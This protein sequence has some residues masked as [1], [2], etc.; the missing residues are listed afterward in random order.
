MTLF[1]PKNKYA[2]GKSFEIRIKFLVYLIFALG[3]IIIGKLFDFQVLKFDFYAALASDQH[4]IYQKLFPDRGSIYLEDK[5]LSALTNQE[6]FYP[7][8]LNKDYNLVYA[9]PKYLTKSPQEAA[10]ILA[11]LLELKE[12]D[13]AAKL[14]KPDD[15][16][17][18]LK[19]KV[20]DSLAETIKNLNLAGIKLSKETY[21]YY[22]EKNIGANVTGFVGFDQNNEKKGQ[23]GIEGYFDK[24]LAGAQ[25]E[26]QSEKDI[27]GSLISVAEQKFVRAVDG[28]DIVLTLDKTVQFEVCSQ[29]D[30]HAK[31]IGADSGSAIVMNPKTGAIIAMCSYPD[32]DPNDY[33]KVE[34]ASAYNNRAVYEAY[35][36]GSIFKAITMAAGLDLGVI[37]PDTTYIDEGFEKIDDFTIRN[38]DHLAHGKNTMSEVL[39]HSLNT[40]TIFVVRQMDRKDFKSYVE[41]FG[42]GEK[43]GIQLKSE[44][45]GNIDSLNKKGEIFTATASFGQG[46]TATSL[47]MV[48]AYSAIANGGKMVSPYIVQEIKK[49]DGTIIKTEQPAPKQVISSKTATLLTGMLVNVVEKG[50]GTMAKVPGYYIA[51]KTGTAQIAEGGAY[52]NRTN[53]SF[54]GFAPIKDPAFVMIIKFENPKKG[55]YAATTTAPLFSR[56]S[57]F[58]LDYYHVVPDKL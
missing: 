38:Y 42:F 12:E 40:G 17:E 35:E 32:F 34:D 3:L 43:T 36:P 7:L 49:F 8:A 39:Q 50:E 21:R 23:Y 30:E 33:G 48:Q 9:Q 55:T 19:H 56:L 44:A 31:V 57:K 15:V 54:I 45:A 51:G 2:Q 13:L 41:K 37:T 25:G 26:I 18:P 11:P 14:S 22:P 24:E 10:K 16:Y 52:S 20:D 47:Q 5:E 27:S 53:H 4:D 1:K 46:I 28:S 29:L 6:S 58:I